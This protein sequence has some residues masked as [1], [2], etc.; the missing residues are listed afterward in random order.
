[1]CRALELETRNGDVKIE[2]S[3]EIERLYDDNRNTALEQF[4]EDMKEY[5]G[6]SGVWELSFSADSS[7][8]RQ[9][10][11]SDVYIL[12]GI[13]SSNSL[14]HCSTKAWYLIAP[15]ASWPSPKGVFIVEAL[16]CEHNA[17]KYEA[18]IERSLSSLQYWIK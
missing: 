3:Y 18:D 10:N 1:M 14:I 5:T 6:Q 17:R 11:G 16:V 2:V 4:A 13:I 9:L 15:V 12:E 7:D 8:K